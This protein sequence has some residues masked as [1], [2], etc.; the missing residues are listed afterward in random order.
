[1]PCGTGVVL[2]PEQSHSTDGWQVDPLGGQRCVPA[3]RQATIH[4]AG[5]GQERTC[6][7][8][9]RGVARLQRTGALGSILDSGL[10][11]Q[12]GFPRGEA[13]GGFWMLRA[14]EEIDD[15][16]ARAHALRSRGQQSE[17]TVVRGVS[18]EP[19]KHRGGR[20]RIFST[21]QVH[22]DWGRAGETG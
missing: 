13:G 8:W 4:S 11:G 21:E 22:R 14:E 6:V 16:R 2:R 19:P 5:L 17:T 20:K 18:N 12:R 7:L 10:A 3:L 1:M 15:Y 9:A